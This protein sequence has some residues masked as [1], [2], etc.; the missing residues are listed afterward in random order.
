M[1]GST[2]QPADL[3][4]VV[5]YHPR[6]PEAY[7]R[8]RDRLV[9][10]TENA[11]NEFEHIGST[12]VPGLAAKPIIDMMVAVTDLAEANGLLLPLEQLGYRLIE[13]G[14]RNRLFLHRQAV[15]GI[16]YNLHIVETT[17]WGDRNERHLRDY[18]IANPAEAEAYG[19]LKARL[20]REFRNDTLGY[21]KAKTAFIQGAI[22]TIRET[23]G[24]PRVDVW[25]D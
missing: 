22:D 16:G 3:V 13:T 9:K 20:A 7:R 10:A 5:E 24:L 23:K 6:W 14:M 4:E 12:A 18:L 11:F 19:A 2:K 15:D 1:T 21:T 17:T 25:E 8:E